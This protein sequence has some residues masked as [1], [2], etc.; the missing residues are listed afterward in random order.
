MVKTFDDMWETIHSEQ[1]WGQ[2]P[3]EEVIRF[4]ARN[5][6]KKDRKSIRIVDMG[7]GNGSVVWFAAREGFDVYGFDG[8]KTAIEK[9]KKRISDENVRASLT[10]CD[11]ANTFYPE[12]FFNAV[13]DSAVIYANR[14]QGIKAILKECYRIL[15]RDGKIFST[16]L[17]K[18]GMTGYCSGE[19]LEENTYREILEGPLSHRGTVH[20]FTYQEIIELWTEAGFKNL[21]IDS[22]ERSDNGGRVEVKYYMVEA[23]K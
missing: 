21:K 18:V 11:A 17:F 14:T 9:A 20:F 15:Q 12:G 7:C 2:Y 6:F 5:F 8:S 22:L 23:E 4:V 3:S 13:I 19:K 16:G 1:D 10:V